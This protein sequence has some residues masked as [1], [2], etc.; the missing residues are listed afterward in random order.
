M[1]LVDLNNYILNDPDENIFKRMTKDSE[2]NLN[3][4]VCSVICDLVNF[5]PMDEE[6]KKETKENI[7][8][9]DEREVGEIA[10]YTSLIPYVQLELKDNKDVAIIA[11]S[12]VEKL[13][14]YVVGYLSKE[15]FDKNLE[16]IQGMLNISYMFYDGLVKYFTF[17][18]EYIVN[19]IEKN[20]K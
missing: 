10:T 4:Y 5:I 12:L 18:K 8:N 15:E 1:K 14:S 11:N 6:L 3:N 20:I 9:C 16:N 13:I 2:A 7:K 17:N 19:T